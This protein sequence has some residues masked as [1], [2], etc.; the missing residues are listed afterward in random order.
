MEPKSKNK[1]EAR[2]ELSEQVFKQLEE[3]FAGTRK[4]FEIPLNPQGTEFQKKVWKALLKIPYGETRSYKEIAAAIGDEKATRAVGMA[5]NKNPIA[6]LI[7]CHRVIG[8]DG[9]LAGYGG[10]VD[11][12][13]RLLE[14]ETAYSG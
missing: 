7:P 9:S 6:I 3:Y 2:T 8:A 11:I 10:G 1:K 12:K 14:T 4:T 13:R 5:N